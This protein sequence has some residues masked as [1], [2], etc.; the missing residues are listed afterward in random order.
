MLRPL[1]VVIA[2]PLG[3]YI[4]FSYYPANSDF[5]SLLVGNGPG[6]GYAVLFFIVG[7]LYV[8]LWAVNFNNKNLISLSKQVR[9]VTNK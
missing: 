8:F 6:R 7:L 4:E 9:E 3:D 2:G 1:G 5:L